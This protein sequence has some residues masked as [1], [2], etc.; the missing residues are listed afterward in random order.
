MEATADSQ[1]PHEPPHDD[2]R[3]SKKPRTDTPETSAGTLNHSAPHAAAAAA[4]DG[5]AQPHIDRPSAAADAA[6]P[7]QGATAAAGNGAPQQHSHSVIPALAAAESHDEP[8]RDVVFRLLVP[9]RI[10]GMVIGKQ[11]CNIKDIE[12]SSGAR[13]QVREAVCGV[14]FMVP[15]STSHAPACCQPPTLH[16]GH[17]CSAHVRGA[18]GGDICTRGRQPAAPPR[19]GRAA[20]A[21]APAARR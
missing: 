19:R 17:S 21:A 18:C 1:H 3:A 13:V 4:L 5:A 9:Q 7:G 14:A 12:A 11:G 2:D 10:V 15:A 16:T 8:G 6:P 20:V